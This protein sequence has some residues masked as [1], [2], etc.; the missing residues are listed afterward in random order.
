MAHVRAQIRDAIATAL[1]GVGPTVYKSRA[2]GIN[3]RPAIAVYT[4]G[5]R[6]D[7][8]A[9]PNGVKIRELECIVEVI[10]EG[11]VDTL[12]DTLDDYCATVEIALNQ[13]K[14][15]GLAKDMYLSGTEIAIETGN[16]VEIPQGMARLTFQATYGTAASDPETAI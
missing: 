15:G 4:K 13:N 5:E 8:P 10:T 9:T 12:D 6:S 11:T 14:L 16:G 1:A 3:T 2:Y 7:R